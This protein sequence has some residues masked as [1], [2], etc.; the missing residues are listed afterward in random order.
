MILQNPRRDLWQ[1]GRQPPL[2]QVRASGSPEG[3]ISLYKW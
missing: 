3:D 1:H 2:Q